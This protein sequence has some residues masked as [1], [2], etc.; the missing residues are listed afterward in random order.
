M[1][2]QERQLS[3]G[4]DTSSRITRKPAVRSC[5]ALPGSAPLDA[6]TGTAPAVFGRAP[7]PPYR[8]KGA[9]PRQRRGTA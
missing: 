4:L 7:N 8:F 5:R 1:Q 3:L 2:G 9:E 6:V